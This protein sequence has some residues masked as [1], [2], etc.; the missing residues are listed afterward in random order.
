M[1]MN[2]V[3]GHVVAGAAGLLAIGVVSASCAHDDTTLFVY[4]VLAAQ[5]VTPPAMCTY[6]ADPTQPYISQGTLDWDIKRSGYDAVVLLGNQLHP[7]ADPNV[8]RTETSYIQVQGA[9][10]R[11]TDSQGHQVANYTRLASATIPPS[12]GSTPGF[13]AIGLT[14]VDSATEAAHV[15]PVGDKVRLITF[16]KFFGVTLGGQSVESNEYEFPVDICQGCLLNFSCPASAS[17]TSQPCIPGQD[18]TVC[19]TLSLVDGGT[20]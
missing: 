9:V 3:L 10:V 8:P 12:S 15:P 16:A 5:L 13:G 1:P 20:D 14:I 6:T 11:I 2:R 7:Q 17:T 19:A 18:D 4:D